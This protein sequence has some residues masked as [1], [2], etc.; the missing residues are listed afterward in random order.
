MRGIVGK[1]SVSGANWR[2]VTVG[3]IKKE[4]QGTP[5]LEVK[6][7]QQLQLI[8][9][10]AHVRKLGFLAYRVGAHRCN[11]GFRCY[12]YCCFACCCFCRVSCLFDDRE[13]FD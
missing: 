1:T 9:M 13:V 7:T 4:E 8:D 11:P 3:K 6:R 2:V 12:C 10:A 5:P